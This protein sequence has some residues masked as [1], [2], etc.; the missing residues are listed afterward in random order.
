MNH[1][2]PSVTKT[3]WCH[4]QVSPQEPG[5]SLSSRWTQQASSDSNLTLWW[6]TRD[7]PK[8]VGY[9][10]SFA[11]RQEHCRG[12][13][14]WAG[15]KFNCI[16]YNRK[17][18]KVSITGTHSQVNSQRWQLTWFFCSNSEQKTQTKTETQQGEVHRHSALMP[19]EA[20]WGIHSLLFGGLHS[21]KAG[22]L[23]GSFAAE[24]DFRTIQVEAELE[25]VSRL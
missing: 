5:L 24:K 19:P 17:L 21:G 13:D 7:F 9:R 10:R 15:N 2:Y 20:A 25:L 22:S 14:G 16:S 18:L 8:A 4:R 3:S 11:R 12:K 1:E 23:P 6:S